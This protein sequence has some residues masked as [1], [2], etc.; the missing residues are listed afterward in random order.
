MTNSTEQKIIAEIKK[1]AAESMALRCLNF[2]IFTNKGRPK[3]FFGSY[4]VL[5]ENEKGEVVYRKRWI[6][7]DGEGNRTACDPQ[8]DD[9]DVY[10]NFY[11]QMFQLKTFKP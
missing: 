6:C 5:E 2:G 1:D 10:R 7:F 11:A 4:K 9:N 3:D 8:F